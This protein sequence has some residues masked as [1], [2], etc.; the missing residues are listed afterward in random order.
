MVRARKHPY[1]GVVRVVSV[2]DVHIGGGKGLGVWQAGTV[3]CRMKTPRRLDGCLLGRHWCNDISGGR[4]QGDTHVTEH[5]VVVQV[6]TPRG[7]LSRAVG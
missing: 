7:L 6:G 4:P 3:R 5:S 1:T 2:G